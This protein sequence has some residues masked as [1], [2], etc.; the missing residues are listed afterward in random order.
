VKTKGEDD[1]SKTLL[2]SQVSPTLAVF[3]FQAVD[4]KIY[5]QKL[6]L[7]VS[8]RVIDLLRSQNTLSESRGSEG[9]RTCEV[10]AD[11]IDRRFP[12]L[13]VYPYAHRAMTSASGPVYPI[14]LEVA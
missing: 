1:V 4:L 3:P 13:L 14:L 10:H 11:F 7:Q 9:C 5:Y 2:V 12:I 8:R 6:L